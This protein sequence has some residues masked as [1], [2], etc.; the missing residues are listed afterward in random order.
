MS[1]YEL[2]N[3]TEVCFAKQMTLNAEVSFDTF[4]KE[5]GLSGVSFGS[6]V[7]GVSKPKTSKAKT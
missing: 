1:F 7:T 5:L 4:G 2:I 3:T 6:L